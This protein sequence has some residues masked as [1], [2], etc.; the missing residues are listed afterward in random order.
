MTEFLLPD[1]IIENYKNNLKTLHEKLDV[2]QNRPQQVPPD[3]LRPIFTTELIIQNRRSTITSEEELTVLDKMDK[4]YQERGAKFP[5]P[6][7]LTKQK[8]AIQTK[9]DAA[10]K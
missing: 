7:W 2:F 3:L 6:D 4:W 9:I 8:I 5:N 10:N 1:L